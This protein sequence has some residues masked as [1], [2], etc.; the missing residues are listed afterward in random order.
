MAAAPV[1]AAVERKSR[2]DRRWFCG[3]R[4]S[5]SS[6][7]LFSLLTDSSWPMDGTDDRVIERGLRTARSSFRSASCPGQGSGW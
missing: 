3:C 6:R 5:H 7:I 1:P 2:R 4:A